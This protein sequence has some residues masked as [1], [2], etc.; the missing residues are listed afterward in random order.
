MSNVLVSVLLEKRTDMDA[1]VTS[2]GGI[3]KTVTDVIEK[4][5]A[6]EGGKVSRGTLVQTWQ[7]IMNGYDNG[8]P[9]GKPGL[10]KL[11]SGEWEFDPEII[12]SNIEGILAGKI[13][14]GSH[15]H[16][17]GGSKGGSV[18]RPTA[19]SELKRVENM[20]KRERDKLID[21]LNAKYR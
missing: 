15:V 18:N 5:V 4:D 20:I 10:Y 7:S 14:V 6:K 12:D 3:K 11:E 17:K 2:Q 9:T 8:L 21:A 16:S 1:I 13:R 19:D